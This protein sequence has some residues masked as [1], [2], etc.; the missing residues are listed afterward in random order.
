MPGRMNRCS[1][2]S[3]A[4]RER[5]GSTTTTVPPRARSAPQPPGKSGAVISEPFEAS[6]LAPSMSR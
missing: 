4:V 3:S 1:S 6:G 5:R 2:A